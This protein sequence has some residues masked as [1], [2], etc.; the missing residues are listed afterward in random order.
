MTAI[1]KVIEVKGDM[2]KVVSQRKSSCSS[3][4]KCEM[5]GNCSAE[6]V[7]GKQTQDVEVQAYNRA[8]AKIGDT[9]EL[10]SS[11]YRT[12]MIAMIVFIF[13]VL[14]SVAAYLVTDALTSN[15]Y[16]PAAV[17]AA[18]LAVSFFI[19]AKIMNSYAMSHMRAEIVKIVEGN[20][21]DSFRGEI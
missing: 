9:V 16:L 14:L 10:Q 18:V 15:Y 12:L 1:A 5:N 11:T 6:L 21:N 4:E 7:F 13:P 19:L 8:G 2:A 20:G 17:L 3:C